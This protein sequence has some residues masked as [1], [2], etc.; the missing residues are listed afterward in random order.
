MTAQERHR[1]I[2]KKENG[3]LTDEEY[4]LYID[5]LQNDP[6]FYNDVIAYQFLED[7]TRNRSDRSFRN[8]ARK[9]LEEERLQKRP[10][11]VPFY[12]AAAAVAVLVSAIALWLIIT[13]EKT[14]LVSSYRQ[15]VFSADTLTKDGKAYAEG[16]LPIGSVAVLWF[17]NSEQ[18]PSLT[19]SYCQ[20][21]LKLYVKADRD[22][23]LLKDVEL[24]YD[25][26]GDTLYWKLPNQSPLP[27][28][29]C[30]PEPQPLAIPER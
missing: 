9:V 4:K 6:V 14:N 10:G 20:D 1:L 21:S 22:T 2:E 3:L 24:R 15:D 13:S 12:Y 19:Y 8:A 30:P 26:V 5:L 23:L 11:P 7:T 28:V 27:F 29:E 18:E 16:K 17:K 25:A